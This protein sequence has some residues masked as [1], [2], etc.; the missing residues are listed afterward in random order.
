MEQN[1]GTQFTATLPQYTGQDRIRARDDSLSP[2][3]LNFLQPTHRIQFAVMHYSWPL[4][5]MNTT[6]SPTP[7]QSAVSLQA[8][9]PILLCRQAFDI[10]LIFRCNRGTDRMTYSWVAPEIYK[11]LDGRSSIPGRG[12][13]FSP[14][15]CAQTGSGAHPASCPL[16]TRVI[17]SGV[18]RPG[19][20]ADRSP[21]AT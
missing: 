6:T 20:E 10:G 8:Y 18:K 2:V 12:W 1:T 5:V 3:I 16:G 9:E 7:C 21:P 13:D 17:S 4:P 15:H 11:G 14:R 19:L